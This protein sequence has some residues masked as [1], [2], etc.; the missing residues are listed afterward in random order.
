MIQEALC[1]PHLSRVLEEKGYNGH[2][3]EERMGESAGVY[4]MIPISCAMRWLREEKGIIIELKIVEH[5][6]GEEWYFD[7]VK[8]REGWLDF[9][10]MCGIDIRF[11]SS[12][13]Q[14]AEAAIHYAV[15]NL[16]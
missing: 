10:G 5:D 12:Y 13:E 4:Y 3:H 2:F 6:H 9:L 16:I 15:E 11:Y 8:R 7:F 14:A 1:K